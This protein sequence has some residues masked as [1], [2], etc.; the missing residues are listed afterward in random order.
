[1]LL[2]TRT[3]A[4]IEGVEIQERLF[5]MAVRSLSLNQMES[6]ITFHHMDLKNAPQTLGHGVFDV[7]TCNPP[8]MP[9]HTGVQHQNEHFALARHE[10]MC[11]LEDVIRV[12]TQLLRPGG[13]ASF[14]HRPSRLMDILSLMRAYRLEPK[15]IRFVH[16]KL[17]KEA[18]MILIEG[19]KDAAPDLKLLPPLIVYDEEN[20]YT[21]ELKEIY[22]GTQGMS[23][24]AVGNQEHES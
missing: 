8:Y 13:R 20:E 9:I 6:R 23:D 15:R 12:S 24:Q 14:V 10:I 3:E 18:N 4:A 2:S 17:G 11:C 19:M 7:V 5:D 1:L 21:A 22:F 16:P